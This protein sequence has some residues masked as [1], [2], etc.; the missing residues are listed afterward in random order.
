MKRFYRS[1][2]TKDEFLHAMDLGEGISIYIGEKV[3]YL[4][5][6][7][8][9]DIQNIL[10]ELEKNIPQTPN[11]YLTPNWKTMKRIETIYDESQR[12]IVFYGSKD[13]V[14][15]YK[16]EGGYSLND[17]YNMFYCE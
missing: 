2:N 6:E 10:F 13:E 9:G 3:F 15:N 7:F 1:Y 17:N 4:E 8:V 16:F 11:F 5:Y 14:M 12:K